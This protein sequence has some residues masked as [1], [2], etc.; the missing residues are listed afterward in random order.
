MDYRLLCT[1]QPVPRM[2]VLIIFIFTLTCHDPTCLTWITGRTKPSSKWSY[3]ESQLN[4]SGLDGLN[5]GHLHSQNFSSHH[6]STVTTERRPVS[7]WGIRSPSP[8]VIDVSQQNH[9]DSLAVRSFPLD[10]QGSKPLL[11]DD[12]WGGSKVILPNITIIYITILGSIIYHHILSYII[13]YYHV[14]S[15]I[16]KNYHISLYILLYHHILSYIIIY[17]CISS[18]IIIYHRLLTYIIINH[19]ILSY[20]IIYYH[21]SNHNMII[22]YYHILYYHL[23][24]IIIYYH[25]SSCIIM[26]YYVLYHITIWLS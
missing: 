11:L 13:I 12:S 23:S 22:I 18:Y 25:I 16:I 2:H 10:K 17:H 5:P 7:V 4:C 24:S 3:S 14:S 8:M 9:M 19:Q 20:I 15:Y 1:D 26:Y 6:Q 21:I